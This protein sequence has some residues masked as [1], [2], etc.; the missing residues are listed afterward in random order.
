MSTFST[1]DWPGTLYQNILQKMIAD[2]VDAWV[3]L[4]SYVR[5][6]TA[7]KAKTPTSQIT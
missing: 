2:P 5:S 3:Q 1:S 6:S 7:P 4:I